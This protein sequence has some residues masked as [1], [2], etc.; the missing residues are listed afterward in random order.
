MNAVITVEARLQHTMACK[1]AF[2]K[3]QEAATLRSSIGTDLLVEKAWVLSVLVDVGVRLLR[4]R[5]GVAVTGACHD[6]VRFESCTVTE[7]GGVLFIFP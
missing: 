2:E 7:H 5:E 4:E 1:A 6:H 3:A